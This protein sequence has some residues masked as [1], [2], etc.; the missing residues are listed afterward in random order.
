MPFATERGA[1]TGGLQLIA[2]MRLPRDTGM[3]TMEEEVVNAVCGGNFTLF[4]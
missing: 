3:F 1:I 4:C 2:E